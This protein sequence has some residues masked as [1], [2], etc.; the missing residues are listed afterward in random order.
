MAIFQGDY[1]TAIKHLERAIEL[2]DS[3]PVAH[4]NLALAYASVGRFDEADQ[5]LKKAVLRGYHQPEVI[6]RRI[7]ELRK[8]SDNSK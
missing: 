5:E 7:E 1:E 6:K 3:Y 8:I 4:S 2:D